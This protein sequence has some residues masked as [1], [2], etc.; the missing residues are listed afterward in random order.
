MS[1]T[2]FFDG[3]CPVCVRE[4][5]QLKNWDTNNELRLIDATNHQAM[6][7]FPHIDPD[8]SMRILHA[9]TFNGD[10]LLGLDANI[11]AWKTIGRKPWLSIL[12]WPLIRPIADRA[13]LFF[14]RHRYRISKILTGKSRCDQCRI[15]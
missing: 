15:G 13:Y 11:A 6:E 4:M 7:A 14:A 8:R 3:S 10:L 9:E 12:R 5:N 1:L 2:L